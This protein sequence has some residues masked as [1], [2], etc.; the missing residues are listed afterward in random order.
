MAVQYAV[1]APNIRA[2]DNARRSSSGSARASVAED[3][4]SRA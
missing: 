1:N 2:C 4:T 3:A